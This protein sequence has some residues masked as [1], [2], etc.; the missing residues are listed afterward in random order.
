[1]AISFLGN[2]SNTTGV[3]TTSFSHSSGSGS[4]SATKNSSNAQGKS[5]LKC[6]FCNKEGHT[7]EFCFKLVGY[8]N[9]CKGK[10]K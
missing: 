6:T 10:G 9:K 4:T 7:R 2:V 1:M 3:K 8:P 5:N